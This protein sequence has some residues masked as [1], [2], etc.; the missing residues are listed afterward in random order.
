MIDSMLLALLRT[1]AQRAKGESDTNER[2]NCR[3]RLKRKNSDS[4]TSITFPKQISSACLD[5]VEHYLLNHAV[6]HKG[7]EEGKTGERQKPK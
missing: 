3:Q 2:A 6:R 1:E 4:S 5:S 7:V